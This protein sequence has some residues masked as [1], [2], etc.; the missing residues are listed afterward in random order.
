MGGY[1]LWVILHPHPMAH[2][3]IFEVHSIFL[4]ETR[5]QPQMSTVLKLKSSGLKSQDRM[6]K[7]DLA[8]KF[9][10]GTESK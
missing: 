2:Q 9:H 8:F 7:N 10:A 3:R 1:R 5:I 4:Q 6:L